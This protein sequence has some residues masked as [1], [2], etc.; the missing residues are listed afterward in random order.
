MRKNRLPILLDT[1][2]F[3]ALGNKDDANYSRANELLDDLLGGKW[4]TRIT[5][6]YVLDEAITVTWVRTKRKELVSQVYEYIFGKEAICLLQP[7]PKELISEAW[8]IFQKYSEPKRLLSFTDCTLLAYA[9][10]R[11]ITFLISF[12]SQFDGLITRIH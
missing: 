5:S 6:D 4:G 1:G 10:N 7:F 8:D 12:D 11:D 9:K 2:F 3:V